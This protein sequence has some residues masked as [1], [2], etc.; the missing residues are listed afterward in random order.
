V[1]TAQ[2]TVLVDNAFPFAD[3]TAPAVVSSATGGDL[4]TNDAELHLFFPPGAFPD[5][6]L[7]S[8]ATT[9]AAADTLGSGAVQAGP[10]FLLTWSA[11][12]NKAATAEFSTQGAPEGPLA[13]YHSPDGSAWTRLGGSPENGK[14]S[15]AITAPGEYALFTDTAPAPEGATSLSALSFTPR[16]FSHAGSFAQDHLAIGFTLGRST[17]V[18]VRVYN[19]AGR[20]VREVVAGERMGPGASLVRW[21]GR[22]RAGIPVA[23]GLYLVSVEALG[24]TQR[25]TVAVVK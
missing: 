15:L 5:D 21:D 1:G 25:K 13:I 9:T 17:P 11:P 24:Q 22:D 2:V 3:Q 23:D 7:V 19:R 6:A 16:V 10:S 4:Y 8:I 18:T 12:L 14:V 20:L